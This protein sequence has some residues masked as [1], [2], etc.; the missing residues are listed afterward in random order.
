[1]PDRDFLRVAWA[2][3]LALGA[4]LP[5]ASARAVPGPDST[6]VIANSNVAESVAL[7]R[8]YAEARRI[9]DRQ[10]CALDLEDPDSSTISMSD[11]QSRLVEPFEACLRDGGVL[12]RIEAVVLVRGVP[13][14]L[15]VGDRRMSLA[16]A[17]GVWKSTYRGEPI[18]GQEPGQLI[19][20]TYYAARF[21]NP[22]TDGVFEPGWTRSEGDFEW[23]PL[24]VT[25]LHGYSFDDAR[26]LI[27]SAMEAEEMG[28]ADGTFMFM[29]GNG[30]PR[31]WYDEQYPDVMAAL[32]EVGYTDLERVPF[33]E[34]L[35]GYELAA[36]FTGTASLG[37]TIEGNEFRPGALVDN[38]TSNG[39]VPENFRGRDEE[40]QVSIARWVAKGVGGVHGCVN[41]PLAGAFPSRA[42]IVDYIDG[43][44][45]AEAYHRRMPQVYWQ[46][47]VLGDAMLA[48]YAVRPE[49]TIDGVAGGDTVGDA[50]NVVV[51]ASDPEGMGIAW[52]AL[53]VDGVE[54]ARVE[55]NRL[56]HCLDLSSGSDV[57]LL[58]VAQKKDDGTYRGAHRPKGWTAVHVDGSG[59]SAECPDPPPPPEDAGT[60][61]TDGGTEGDGGVPPGR[62]GG[63]GPSADGGDDD[64]GSRDGRAGGGCTVTP[65]AGPSA[66]APLVLA[67]LLLA[68]RRRRP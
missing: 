32:E 28:G 2:I 62:D 10:V 65:I 36:F 50:R 48:P 47:L 16:A 49:I 24:L 21:P 31:N 12:E 20:G 63:T 33:D 67:S 44:T 17:L 68:R 40:N 22:F 7:A 45:L 23:E 11:F 34:N 35:T 1:M 56:V 25:M 9:P 8:D 29:N 66:A 6:A 15:R 13:I 42:L 55:G 39:A 38:L 60:G 61:G 27:T 37:D 30:S 51:R 14:K 41:E 18:M 59:G 52:L 5:A 58:A 19:D 57:Q 3:T 64:A 43:G 26:K 54:V 4:L 46:N 53:F